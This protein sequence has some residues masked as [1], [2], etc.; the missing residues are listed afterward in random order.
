MNA[1]VNI[2]GLWPDGAGA[3]R[4]GD[5]SVRV[6]G[7]VPGDRATVRLEQQRGKVWRGVV[8]ALTAPSPARRARP[9]PWSA[10]CGGCDLDVLT[11]D[12]RRDA[13]AAS[14]ARTLGLADPPVF[15]PSP[16]DPGHRA[17]VTLE[18][19]DGQ[20][21]FHRAGTTEIV[22]VGACRAARPEVEA[23]LQ[24]VARWVAS[25]PA[26]S[27]SFSSVELRSD[28]TH[29]VAALTRRADAPRGVAPLPELPDV[30]VGGR[31]A[32][33]DTTSRLEVEGF[34]LEAGPESFY[35]VNLEV[36][37]LMVAW[38]VARAAE[39]KPERV[40]ELY[41]GIGNLTL[42]LARAV[43]VPVVA[44]E[45]AGPS[46][47]DLRVNLKKAVGAVEAVTCDV[48]R[49]DLR[50]N[51]YDVLVLDPP[52]AGAGP[53]LARALEQRPRRVVYVSCNVPALANE[54]ARVRGYRVTD[55]RLFDMF[56]D[57]HHVEAVVVLDRH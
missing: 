5:G 31:V 20:V 49:Y 1:E 8:E 44:V 56:P 28:G 55:V 36:N 14:V 29:V 51:P 6:D 57:T 46:M 38:V 12:A 45:I 21:G 18:L 52:R 40:L 43:G 39:A 47:R 41:A 33:G 32:R 53:A 27:T 42:P 30:A 25:D 19:R 24:V 2:D 48:G 7:L 54:L 35:Q 16:R 9:C 22:P 34:V 26:A 15:V 10:T 13:V 17:R 3:G 4:L 37:R 23:A 50:A 11:P